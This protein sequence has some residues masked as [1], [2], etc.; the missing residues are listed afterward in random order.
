VS[1]FLQ[2]LNPSHL[3]AALKDTHGRL[4]CVNAVFVSDV[5]AA[6]IGLGVEPP[7]AAKPLR[8][9]VAPRKVHAMVESDDGELMLRYAG[10][11]LRAFEALY[12]RHRSPLYRYLARHTR[13]PEV[14]NDIFQEVWSRVISSRSR[15]E[16]RAKFSTFLY[17][18]AH[19]CFID[20]C[21][22]SSARQ[23]RANVSNEDF[24][25]EKILPA[26]AADLPDTRAEHAQ[27]L[28]RYRSALASLPADQR[29]TFLLYEESGLTLE[30][31][32]NITGVSMETAKSRLRYALSKLRHAM[33][34]L[35]DSGTQRTAMVEEPGA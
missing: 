7:A 19:N 30:E 4:S 21:R 28:A 29:D 18:I 34:S 22:R 8:P 12:R 3:S 13:D 1:Q 14:A 10:G 9:A 24:E 26:P 25:L 31:I 20:H 6:A 16:P 23:D 5:S 33:S 15:Y 11:D 27:T 17:R 35:R 32:G 2:E